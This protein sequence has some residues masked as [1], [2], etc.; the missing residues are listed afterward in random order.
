M[1]A[2][3]PQFSKIQ[4]IYPCVWSHLNHSVFDPEI[5]SCGF[6]RQERSP[7]RR[8]EGERRVGGFIAPNRGEVGTRGC[9]GFHHE[10]TAIC[11]E[12]CNLLKSRKTRW[13]WGLGP[14]RLAL[15]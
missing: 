12:A 10:S 2:R 14:C 1:P 8:S 6:V 7:I 5:Q 11:G 15:A 4:D 3:K 13:N 9:G